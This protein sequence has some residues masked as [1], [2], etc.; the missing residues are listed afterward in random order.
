MRCY[1]R[2]DRL[3][4]AVSA[5]RRLKQTLSVLLGL[6]PSP[7]TERLYRSLRLDAVPIRE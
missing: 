4:E 1:H 5:Y 7:G 3:P 6:P 2:L